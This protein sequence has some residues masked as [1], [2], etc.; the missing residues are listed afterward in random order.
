[1]YYYFIQKIMYKKTFDVLILHIYEYK[2]IY[3]KNNRLSC[4]FVLKL[5]L[6][7]GIRQVSLFSLET[8]HILFILCRYVTVAFQFDL[9]MITS[10]LQHLK[11]TYHYTD[12]D[13]TLTPLWY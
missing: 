9:A 7:L 12:T 1:M 6:V 10:N 11:L 3:I 2:I 8:Y 13:V 4:Y 5:Q